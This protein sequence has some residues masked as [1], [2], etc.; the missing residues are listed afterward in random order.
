MPHLLLLLSPY[1]ELFFPTHHP[2][3]KKWRNSKAVPVIDQSQPVIA[4]NELSNS[5]IDGDGRRVIS[6]CHVHF[7]L[8]ASQCNVACKCRA[9]IFHFFRGNGK[10]RF[11]AAITEQEVE[12]MPQKCPY[13]MHRMHFVCI[14]LKGGGDWKV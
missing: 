11:P 9:W 1:A 6:L 5:F 7:I 12:Q 8:F 3:E 4:I 14:L 2:A 10:Q 13:L